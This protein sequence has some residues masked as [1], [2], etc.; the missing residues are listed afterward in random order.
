MV[1]PADLRKILLLEGLPDA[2][3]EEMLP[4]VQTEELPKGSVVFE[5]GSSARLFRMLKRGKVLLEVEVAEGI[6]IS[7]GAVKSGYSFGWSALLGNAAHTTYAVTAEPCDILSVEGARFLEILQR[8]PSAGYMIMT[9]VFHIFK[10]RLERRTGQFIRV[11]QKHPD[12]QRLLG[13]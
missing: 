2:L 1:S 11:M 5:E 9:R 13:L 12:I 8:S 6:I 4:H 7:L 10:R 3:L